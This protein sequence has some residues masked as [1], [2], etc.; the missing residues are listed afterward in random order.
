MPFLE[1][2]Y[3]EIIKKNDFKIYDNYEV[4]AKTK[5][6]IITVGT[7]LQHHIETN[8]DHIKN[9]LK[10]I[11]PFLK[12]GHNIILRSTVTMGTTD[13]VKKTIQK[14]T[15]L[16]VGKEIFVSFCPERI[17]EG[18]AFSEL[19][20]LPQ[21]IGADEDIAFDNSKNVFKVLTKEIIRTNI[22]EA[23]LIK[24]FCNISRYMQFSVVNYLAIVSET[25]KCDIHKLLNIINKD[26]PRPIHGNVGFTAGTCLRKD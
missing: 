7:P 11:S 14:E 18:K 2:S 4:V 13:Y 22:K 5:N 23:E 3:D 21:I 25:Y 20:S 12:K 19:Q 1:D 9:V 17:A 6:I 26:Y 24:L 15:N 16:K 8:L 10:S